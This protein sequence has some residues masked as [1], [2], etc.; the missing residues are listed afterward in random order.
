M[1]GKNIS[2][3]E[4]N[5]LDWNIHRAMPFYNVLKLILSF[6]SNGH[7]FGN[8]TVMQDHN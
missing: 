5:H 6:Y 4:N 1:E 7:N 8:N 2:N 3:D